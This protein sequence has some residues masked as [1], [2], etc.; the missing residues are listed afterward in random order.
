MFQSLNGRPA[1][2]RKIVASRI[3]NVSSWSIVAHSTRSL[4][5]RCVR[6][7]VETNAFMCLFSVPVVTM[8]EE[9]V[10]LYV[11]CRQLYQFVDHDHLSACGTSDSYRPA[12]FFQESA[13]YIFD[14]RI[15]QRMQN[16]PVRTTSRKYRRVAYTR[17]RF[18]VDVLSALTNAFGVG[19]YRIFE[20]TMI[21]TQGECNRCMHKTKFEEIVT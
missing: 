11:Y 19:T 5:A 16:V 18:L 1:G 12:Y 4:Y 7:H 15:D 13:V 10:C 2:V 21:C 14:C 8:P 17:W 9:H 20:A 3:Y 6:Y